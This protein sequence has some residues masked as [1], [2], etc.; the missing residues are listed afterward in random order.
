MLLRPRHLPSPVL[1]PLPAPGDRDRPGPRNPH[2]KPEHR[3]PARLAASLPK[4]NIRPPGALRHHFHSLP[5]KQ[6]SKIR[7]TKQEHHPPAPQ[8]QISE[9]RTAL[10]QLS[11][12]KQVQLGPSKANG[13]VAASQAKSHSQ[14][15]EKKAKTSFLGHYP[16]LSPVPSRGPVMLWDGNSRVPRTKDFLHRLLVLFPTSTGFQQIG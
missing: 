12:Y 14:K 1:P 7:Q 13:C 9:H 16:R 8:K 11:N 10:L 15:E 6:N 2:P 3:L 5:S 4:I